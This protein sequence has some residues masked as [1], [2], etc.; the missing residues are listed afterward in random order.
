MLRSLQSSTRLSG[1]EYC[2]ARVG[3][4]MRHA[5]T[6]IVFAAA[7]VAGPAAKAEE[8]VGKT[9]TSTGNFFSG[10]AKVASINRYT[11][12]AALPRPD[13]VVIQDFAVPPGG[14]TIDDS[15]AARLHRLHSKDGDST[16]VILSQHIQAAFSD[17][18]KSELK[19]VNV[20]A[21]RSIAGDT[22]AM[23]SKLI[24]NGQFVAIDEG[25]QTKRMMIGF[26]R[27]ASDLKTHVMIS[28]TTEGH[29]TVVLEF[30]LDS[31]SNKMPGA[32]VTG[33]GSLAVGTAV[34]AVGDRGSKIEAD[35]ARMG[36]LVAKQIE[37]LMTDRK[38]V[39]TPSARAAGNT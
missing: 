32:L 14:I 19:K 23:G 31:Q 11:A 15:L 2:Q 17:A 28:S 35:A 18:L 25:N 29:S 39:Y 30:D 27:G 3:I 37:G 26:G 34:S 21:N 13:E 36:K 22:G 16:A 12:S 7:L 38:W 1:R 6:G 5:L 10:K 20:P 4:D 33:V 24:V 8:S 9:P